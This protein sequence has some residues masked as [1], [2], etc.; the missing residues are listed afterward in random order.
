VTTGWRLLLVLP[1]VVAGCA[2]PQPSV[3][4]GGKAVPVDVAFGLPPATVV[5]PGKS[6]NVLV[7][8]PNGLGVL[9]VPETSLP[10]TSSPPASVPATP[11]C[12]EPAPG[13][14]PKEAAQPV[15]VGVPALGSYRVRYTAKVVE[16]GVTRTFGGT[17]RHTVTSATSLP[18]GSTTFDVR[19]TM[20]GADTTFT[21][22][23]VPTA[24]N[25]LGVSTVG[26]IALQ[27]AAGSAGLGYEASFHP[28]NPMTV[29]PQPAFAG[30]TFSSAGTDASSGAVARHDGTVRGTAT[31]NVC[32][33]PFD[34]WSVASTLTSQSANQ[35]LTTVLTTSF[36]TA[37]G[38]LP[39]A[40]TET[41]SGTAG[42]KEVSGSFTWAFSDP[43]KGAV[44]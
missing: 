4:L 22:T 10:P 18:G 11:A 39:I 20:L 40:Q 42:G 35:D 14:F 19:V 2:G 27:S 21:W 28:A 38:G 5:P 37:Q 1:L 3:S 23:T 8:V 7:P 6:P 24:S 32:G 44:R 29:M 12:P 25:A 41:Y 15:V 43:V 13:V 16:D 34:T 31:V 9:P 33:T 30:A 17:A 36:A 26:Q